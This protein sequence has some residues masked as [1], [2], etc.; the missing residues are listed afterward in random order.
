MMIL[1][2]S[3]PTIFDS[4]LLLYGGDVPNAIPTLKIENNKGS[5]AAP[6]LLPGLF[7]PDSLDVWSEDR[8]CGGG[9]S[10]QLQDPDLTC[11]NGFPH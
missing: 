7:S 8:L 5:T 4:T 1:P 9:A 3:T 10:P 6:L 2:A 11:T